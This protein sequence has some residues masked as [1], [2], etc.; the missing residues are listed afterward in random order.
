MTSLDIVTP[1]LNSEEYILSTLI[2]LGSCSDRRINHII[3]DSYSSDSTVDIAHANGI[4]VLRYPPGNM[5]SA[6][7][8][9]LEHGSSDWCAYINSDD[10]IYLDNVASAISDIED[11]VDIV[12]GNADYIDS[13]GRFLHYWRAPAPASLGYLLKSRIMPFPQQTMIFRRRVF[14]ELGGFCN[15][16]RYSADFD[17]VL[18]AYLAG[19]RFKKYHGGPMAAFRLHPGQ[20]SANKVT[21]MRNEGSD[22]LWSNLNCRPSRARRALCT[23][24]FLR[25][26]NVDSYLIRVLRAKFLK[27]KNLFPAS[28]ES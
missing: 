15:R 8:F 10:L 9:G 26:I 17:F 27:R 24:L 18:R 14:E 21:D 13:I 16:Y 25:S 28:I 3:V 1:T 19:Y 22:A 20:I 7:N 12:Y 4:R 11:N 23:F 5:Y 2:S 6:I